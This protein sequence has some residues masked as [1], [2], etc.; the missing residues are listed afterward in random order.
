MTVYRRLGLEVRENCSVEL[1]VKLRARRNLLLLSVHKLPIEFWRPRQAPLAVHRY[2][3][4]GF[5]YFRLH[6]SEAEVCPSKVAGF[7]FRLSFFLPFSRR[8]LADPICDDQ[9]YLYLLY[10]ETDDHSCKSGSLLRPLIATSRL[11]QL[12]C[13]LQL[14]EKH[15]RV[16]PSVSGRTDGLSGSGWCTWCRN[17]KFSQS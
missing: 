2:L 11:T 12:F 7:C 13:P 4:R 17:A 8:R 15:K 10:S 5:G 14:L 6:G 1:V 3:L 16:H 9:I